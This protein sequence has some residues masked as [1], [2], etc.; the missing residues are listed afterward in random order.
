MNRRLVGALLLLLPLV[1]FGKALLG[2]ET[3]LPVPLLRHVAPWEKP[4]LPIPWNVLRFDAL[5]QFYPWRREVARQ[6]RTGKLPLHNPYAFAADGGTPLWANS[7][8]APLYPPN[9]IFWLLP[10]GLL[11][12]GFGLSA[13]LHLLL[14]AVGVYRFARGVG[15]RR[16]PALLSACAFSLSGPIVC[17]LALPTFLCVAAWLPWLLIAIRSALAHAGTPRG[18]SSLVGA[19][20]CAG[21]A[22]LGG[23]LQIAFYVLGAGLL[24]T[25]WEVLERKTPLRR[26]APGGLAALA[27][28]LCLAAPQVL[29]A[30]ELS[31]NSHRASVG[32]PSLTG[33][34]SYVALALPV[35]SLVTFA[36]PDYFGHPADGTHWND[37]EVQ[38]VVVGGNNY[39]EWA[40]YVGIGPLLLALVA[41]LLPW[42]KTD[43]E[44][45]RLRRPLAALLGISLLL[46]LGTPLNLLLYFGLPGFSQT[47]SPARI[48]LLV[49]LALA[50][51]AGIGLQLLEDSSL[52]AS[53]RRRVLWMAVALLSIV[54]SV[55]AAQ[56]ATWIGE[57]S[58]LSFAQVIQYGLPDIRFGL[59]LFAIVLIL[60]GLLPTYP[61]HRN[62]AL[63]GF[64]ALTLLD[65][66]PRALRYN[67][68]GPPS[69]L[70]PE[71]PGIAYLKKNARGALIAPLNVGWSMGSSSPSAILPPNLLTV[72]ELRD[73]AG[74]DSLY[75]KERRMR[76]QQADRGN[77][78]AP[79]Q[80][81]N[82]AFVKSF[83]AAQALGASF[84]V[85]HP[86]I[87]RERKGIELVYTG[88]DMGIYAT[89]VVEQPA[90]P[91][92]PPTVGLRVGLFF[93]AL[94]LAALGALT[95]ALPRP[96]RL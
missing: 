40:G 85:V 64:L 62:L 78:P 27:L 93:G 9:L 67:V 89:G 37:S 3:L 90:A 20:L 75:P 96:G 29:P 59:V 46:A 25:L 87:A 10:P 5:A 54:C 49:A 38:G 31:K 66:L 24:W 16:A 48:L 68:G 95:V 71:T 41:L 4:S 55:A 36:F 60:S 52:P 11:W 77:D 33:Y 7:Q 39:A 56:S 51:L 81:G 42:K 79:P 84:V 80:N 1:L 13:A 76:L 58:N 91:P 17:W 61:G 30:V 23:H 12:Y 22:M 83:M 14:A 74:Y 86:R 53:L 94:G 47:G 28:A 43:D 21:L 8:S 92:P 44:L 65:L 72:F 82:M 26:W 69:D 70:L 19:G 15:L 18:I 63:V 35:R 88:P 50:M 45:S 57:V 32:G 2:R 73:A 34:K 6:W